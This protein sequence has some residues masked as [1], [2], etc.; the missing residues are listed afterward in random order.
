[1]FKGKRQG[2]PGIRTVPYWQPIGKKKMEK[3]AVIG[4]RAKV[5]VKGRKVVSSLQKAKLTK[6]SRFGKK[7]R[8]TIKR[9]NVK[10]NGAHF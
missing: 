1:L 9:D 8:E 5:K 2:N 10:G 3:G 4:L 6:G 7:Q